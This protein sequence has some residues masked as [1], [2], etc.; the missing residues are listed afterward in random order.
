LRVRLFPQFSDHLLQIAGSSDI[1]EKEVRV[2]EKEEGYKMIYRKWS[3]LSS[4]AVITTG[5]VGAFVLGNLLFVNQDP[6][7]KQVPKKQNASSSQ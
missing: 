1:K 7:P 4:T 5:I 6:F 3:L 2:S